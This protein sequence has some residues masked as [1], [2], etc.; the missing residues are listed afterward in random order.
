[1]DSIDIERDMPMNTKQFKYALLLANEKSFSRAAEILGISQPSLSQYLKKIESEVGAKLFDRSGSEVRLTDAGRAYIEAGKKILD[2]EHQMEGKIAD[3]NNDIKGS[4]VVG[5]SPYRTISLM[6]E[7][8]QRFTAKYPGFKVCL[9]ERTGAELLEGSERGE[10]D[11]CIT[12]APV[13]AKKFDYIK[14]MDE[15]IVLAAP[16]GRSFKTVTD[17]DRKYP[18]I[19]ISVLAKENIIT[20]SES[21]LM[22]KMLDDICSEYGISYRS[23]VTCTSIKAQ[24]AMIREGLGIAIVPAGTGNEKSDGVRYYSIKQILPKREIVV[25]YRKEQ[26]LSKPIKDFIEVLKSLDN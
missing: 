16:E 25:A 2:I 6:P 9:E 21:Q 15:E 3:I 22:Q 24:I 12:P 23:S 7:A 19:D 8:I 20:L 17:K 14:I 26:Y 13:D 4:I 10:Y 18:V 1:M 5:I 11:L